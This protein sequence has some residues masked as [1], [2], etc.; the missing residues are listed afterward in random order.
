M[1]DGIPKKYLDEDIKDAIDTVGYNG[2]GMCQINTDE[3]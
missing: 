3:D 1:E 2:H